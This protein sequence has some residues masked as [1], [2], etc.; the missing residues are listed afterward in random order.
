MELLLNKQINLTDWNSFVLN[1]KFNSPFQTPEFY[2][3]YNSLVNYSAEVFA[4][5]ENAKLISLC[6]VTL[7]REKGIKSYFSKRAIIYGGPL[8]ENNRNDALNI[9]LKSIYKAL[10]KKVIYLETRNFNDYKEYQLNFET[11]GWKYV[12]YLN[13]KIQLTGKTMNDIL[14]EM[15]YNRKREIKLSQK[16]ETIYR[17]A[18]SQEEVIEL[19]SILSNLYKTRV[20]LPLPPLNYFIS[21]FESSIGKVFIVLH[22]SK[23]IGGSFCY[24]LNGSSIYTLY[25]CGV[26][27]YHKKIFPTHLSILAAIDFGIDKKLQTLDLMGAGKLGEE[28]GVRNY[29][30]EFGGELVEHGRFIKVLNNPLFSIGKIGLKFKKLIGI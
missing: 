2:S 8:I 21:L 11:N 20:K 30:A 24:Y 7:Q 22:N 27:N 12:P 18:V 10:K 17:I 5:K 3:L 6:V 16:L 29:K 13:Y 25:Y 14:S 28:Y 15:K 19:Y 9:L 23:I 1:N 26:R 4:I